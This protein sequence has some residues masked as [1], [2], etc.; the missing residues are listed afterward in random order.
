MATVP[1]TSQGADELDWSAFRG[2]YFPEA[3]RHDLKAIAAYG[4][5]KSRRHPTRE[6]KPA[7][8][9]EAPANG[10]TDTWEGEGGASS[11]DG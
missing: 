1:N 10:A 5:Y 9:T 6:A 7:H 3:R 8:G 11:M 4:L 2:R